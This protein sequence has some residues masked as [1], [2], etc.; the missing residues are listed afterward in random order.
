MRQILLEVVECC[1]IFRLHVV[2]VVVVAVVVVAC[3]DFV[4]AIAMPMIL[5]QPAVIICS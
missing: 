5:V 1:A 4:G 2:V 3:D